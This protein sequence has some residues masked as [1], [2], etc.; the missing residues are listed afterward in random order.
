MKIEQELYRFF[1]VV[2]ECGQVGQGAVDMEVR[3]AEVAGEGVEMQ[4]AILHIGVEIEVF[5]HM[6]EGGDAEGKVSYGEL[7]LDAFGELAHGLLGHTEVDE[8]F[9]I[10]FEVD[11]AGD[12]LEVTDAEEGADEA[13]FEVGI[14]LHEDFGIGEITDDE[15]TGKDSA[16]GFGGDIEEFEF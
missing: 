1:L 8:F 12:A 4:E 15:I 7:A 16:A 6:W 11:V 9:E 2:K 10:H 3:V 13:E 5:D 14:Y